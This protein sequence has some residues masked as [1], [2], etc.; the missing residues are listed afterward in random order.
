MLYLDLLFV[1]ESD[2]GWRKGGGNLKTTVTGKKSTLLKRCEVPSI[3]TL[4]HL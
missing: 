3:R 4:S 2:G 1:L